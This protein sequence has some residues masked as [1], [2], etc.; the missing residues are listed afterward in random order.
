MIDRNPELKARERA[1]E[2]KRDE[3]LVD[4]KKHE[5]QL[6]TIKQ[7]VRDSGRMEDSKY[8]QCC[9]AQSRH[10]QAI[11]KIEGLLAP[12]KHELREIIVQEFEDRQVSIEVRAV[13]T[14][15][16]K[17]T[18]QAL[19]ALREQYQRFAADHTR[20][21]SMREM[22]AKFVLDLNEIIKLAISKPEKA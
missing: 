10:V 1:L 21:S 20:V 18:V 5:T 9:Q 19:V 6:S 13:E 16:L 8:R 2:R 4:K 22:T 12:I 15:R 17:Q 11:A 7:L 3:L 14:I